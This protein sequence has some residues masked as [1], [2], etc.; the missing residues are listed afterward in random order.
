MAHLDENLSLQDLASLVHLSPEQTAQELIEIGLKSPYKSSVPPKIVRAYLQFKGFRIPKQVISFQMLKGGVAKTTS[1]LNLGWRAAMYGSRVLMIDLDQQANLT[2]ALGVD[3]ENLP[4]WVDI[5]EKKVTPSQAILNIGEGLDL[6]PSSLN[7]S[8]LDRVLLQSNR[9]WAQSV[10]GPLREISDAYDLILID[11]APS[12]SILNTAVTCASNVV[13][14]PINPDKFSMSG[15][16]K[17]LADLKDLEKE[18]DLKLEKRVL[19]TRFDGREM[20]SR[21]ILSQCV[22]L[23]EDLLMKNY[24]R[25]SS[26]VKNTLASGKTIFSTKNSAKED[27]DLVTRELLHFDVPASELGTK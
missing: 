19:F 12:L 11:T 16:Q 6:I 26:E 8:V 9:N 4:V 3:A 5:V 25:S 7:N 18:F 23:F 17:H 27:Y 13:V 10:K 14:L 21:E 2:F 24:I 15:V 1:A 22:D 20:A